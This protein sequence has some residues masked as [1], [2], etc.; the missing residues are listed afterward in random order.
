MFN[1]L[2]AP[3]FA[4]ITTS[5]HFCVLYWPKTCQGL[6]SSGWVL[7]PFFLARF[8]QLSSVLRVSLGNCNFHFFPQHLCLFKSE[9]GEGQLRTLTFLCLNNFLV[10][11]AVCLESL[12]CWNQNTLPISRVALANI[13][14]FEM[15]WYMAAFGS[16]EILC[17]WCREAPLL[18]DGPSSVFY[19]WHCTEL[20]VLF[21]WFLPQIIHP[22][23]AKELFFLMYQSIGYWRKKHQAVVYILSHTQISCVYAQLSEVASSI[24][25]I[26][27]VCFCTVQ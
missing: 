5:K 21:T 7:L 4:A 17:F 2:Y 14:N 8:F 6:Q 26:L 27:I 10:L 15:S 22:F 23:C 24:I 13:W 12:S 25:C 19:W 1:I 11:L 3:P 18:H 20:I 16:M 9:H